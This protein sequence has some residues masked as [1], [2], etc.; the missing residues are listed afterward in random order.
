MDAKSG[1]VGLVVLVCMLVL[2]GLGGYALA[3]ETW[4][5]ASGAVFLPV[6]VRDHTVCADFYDDFS[7][8]ASGWEVAEDEY[9]RTE[10]LNGEYRLLTKQSG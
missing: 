5:L 8:P 7:N 6:V 9:A 1:R 4:E 10:Y 2:A 3:A